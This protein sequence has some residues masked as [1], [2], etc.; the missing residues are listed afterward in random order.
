[1]EDPVAS[2]AVSPKTNTKDLLGPL[3]LTSDARRRGRGKGRE[4]PMGAGEVKLQ[5]QSRGSTGQTSPPS[6]TNWK[7]NTRVPS[8]LYKCIS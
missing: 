4:E 1:M 5:T 7:D 3:S 6:P 8:S 2:E